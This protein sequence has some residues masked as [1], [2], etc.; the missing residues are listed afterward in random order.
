MTKHLSSRISS[1]VWPTMITPFTANGNIDYLALESL[2]EWYIAQKASGLFAVC[3]SSEMFFLSR[4]ERR[5]LAA[6]VVNQVDGRIPVIASGHISDSIDEQVQDISE[7]ASAGVDAVVLV[8]NRLLPQGEADSAWYKNIDYILKR[9]PKDIQLGMYEC[10]Y[11]YKHVLTRNM[12]HFLDESER[13][14]FLK[15]TVSI[16]AVIQHRASLKLENLKLFNA[17]SATL[18]ASLKEGYDGFSGV[19]ANFHP[20]LY[21]WLFENYAKQLEELDQLQQFLSLSSM[22]ESYGYPLNAKLYLNEFEGIPIHL[23]QRVN[24]L[25]KLPLSVYPILSDLKKQSDY[26]LANLIGG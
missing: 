8:S 7:I 23:S 12:L 26:W 25:K 9:I 13:F 4:K 24:S 14:T 10:P 19:M 16:P 17:N 21:H 11:P 2:V 22:I 20:R 6:A 18:L 1:G 5:Q 3:Q 15:D